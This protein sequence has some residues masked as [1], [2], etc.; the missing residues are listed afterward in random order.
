MSHGK[1]EG[2]IALPPEHQAVLRTFQEFLM[3]PGRM[4]CFYGHDLERFRNSLT[5][6]SATGL[7]RRERFSGGYSL[8]A[9][10]YEAMLQL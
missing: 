4:L 8:T 5:E 7:L 10:G 9:I 1:E 6:L 2:K 3:T